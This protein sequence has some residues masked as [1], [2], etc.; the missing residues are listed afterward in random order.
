MQLVER[1]RVGNG[2]CSGTLIFVER[3][4]VG[5]RC[6]LIITCFC[7]A[8]C[9]T[10]EAHRIQ[11]CISNYTRNCNKMS[12]DRSHLQA[13]PIV[14]DCAYIC[15]LTGGRDGKANCVSIYG[16][17]STVLLS[18]GREREKSLRPLFLCRYVI[19]LASAGIWL[20]PQRW[21]G[22]G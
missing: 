13:L 12:P 17:V 3:I 21:Q 14:H 9:L 1:E 20:L 11:Y 15:K 8:T 22:S 4:Y 2:C 6:L 19:M 18:A 10:N 5:E 7:A 16:A